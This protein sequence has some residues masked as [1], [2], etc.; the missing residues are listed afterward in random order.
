MKRLFFVFTLLLAPVWAADVLLVG[1]AEPELAF[2]RA[3]AFKPF[4]ARFDIPFDEAKTLAADARAAL[5]A[6]GWP[7][8]VRELGNLIERLSVLHADQSVDILDLPSKYRAGFLSDEAMASLLAD[9]AAA[10]PIDEEELIEEE[11]GV[12]LPDLRLDLQ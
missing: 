10:E 4:H 1:T 9:L 6:Y 7:G 12:P 3:T 11:P 2:V 8:N 5:E